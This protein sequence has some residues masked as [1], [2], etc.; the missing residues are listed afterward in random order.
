M[1]PL[2]NW[3]SKFINHLYWLVNSHSRTVYI[4]QLN[5][6]FTVHETL[7]HFKYRGDGW[8]IHWAQA[9]ET[10]LRRMKG[11]CE[12]AAILWQHYLS[13]R[14]LPS[15]LY[16]LYRKFLCFSLPWHIVCISPMAGKFYSNAS[17]L[18][19]IGD[20]WKKSVLDWYE[21][22]YTEMKEYRA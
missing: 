20:N 15:K 1:K 10:S 3:Y 22:K 13:L 21:D 6:A 12:D 11:D 7:S 9:P 5:N 18:P 16:C 14:Y 2:N 19:L 8:L 17:I 4:S